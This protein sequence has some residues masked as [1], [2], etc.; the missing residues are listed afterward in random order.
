MAGTTLGHQTGQ[1]IGFMAIVGLEK[2]ATG[3]TWGQP[4]TMGMSM[5]QDL[6]MKTGRRSLT[7]TS[8]RYFCQKWQSSH[9]TSTV[10]SNQAGI[11]H[12]NQA[13]VDQF[14]PVGGPISKPVVNIAT[15]PRGCSGSWTWQ[16]PGHPPL[17]QTGLM[18]VQTCGARTNNFTPS[19]RERQRGGGGGGGGAGKTNIRAYYLS[20]HLRDR[21]DWVLNFDIFRAIN[22]LWG[23][24]GSGSFCFSFLS[25]IA[26]V[27]QL[28]SRP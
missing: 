22:T 28:E 17:C 24:N 9:W 25:T 14:K 13:G 7:L 12:V 19:V 16:G 20:R 2:I 6:A 15:Q 10:I 4:K 5:G 23:P 18:V 11:Q 3:A 8:V 27:L 21:T 26:A 1:F